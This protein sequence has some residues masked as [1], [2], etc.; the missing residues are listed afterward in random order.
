MIVPLA[1]G[2][3]SRRGNGRSR[4]G[5]SFFGSQRCCRH[6]DCQLCCPGSA[7]RTQNRDPNR[8]GLYVNIDDQII[9][10]V[11]RKKK[12]EVPVKFGANPIH[13]ARI[14]P[15]KIRTCICQRKSRAVGSSDWLGL[16]ENGIDVRDKSR[17]EAVAGLFRASPPRR[18]TVVRCVVRREIKA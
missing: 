5:P 14:M 6:R 11:L 13:R 3:A 15:D 4:W 10:S 16:G 18:A 12:G 2:P 1:P 8:R 9:Q 17:M 7:E